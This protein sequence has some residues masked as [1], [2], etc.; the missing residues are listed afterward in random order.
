[1]VNGGAARTPKDLQ[2]NLEIDLVEAAH[3]TS[4]EVSYEA[5]SLCEHCNGNGAEPGTPIET[6]PRCGG[7]GQLRAVTR[8]PFG[9]FNTLEI[10]AKGHPLS[11]V[12]RTIT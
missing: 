1:M 9:W 5:V 8:T 4:A 12:A 2:Y 11:R 6:C 7:S 3:G 10:R